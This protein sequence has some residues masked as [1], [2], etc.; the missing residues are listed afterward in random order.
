MSPKPPF[1]FFVIL[2]QNAYLKIKKGAPFSFFWKFQVFRI[3]TFASLVSE[4][5]LQCPVSL[6]LEKLHDFFGLESTVQIRRRLL[7]A[8]DENRVLNLKSPFLVGALS[9]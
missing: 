6:L 1:E 4:N 2:Q 8:Q 9:F 3:K 7:I 5:K